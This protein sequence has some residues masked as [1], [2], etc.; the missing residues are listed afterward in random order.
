MKRWTV[1]AFG[2]VSCLAIA[3]S[4][5]KREQPPAAPVS[6]QGAA[7]TGDSPASEPNAKEPDH[8]SQV[9]KAE[10]PVAS[11]SAIAAGE[12]AVPTFAAQLRGALDEGWK[13]KAHKGSSEERLL[14]E[15]GDQRKVLQVAWEATEEQLDGHLLFRL[16]GS[17]WTPWEPSDV[18]AFALCSVSNVPALPLRQL[19]ARITS[20]TPPFRGVS[21]A[22]GEELPAV[23]ILGDDWYRYPAPLCVS[24]D[25]V[26]GP[27]DAGN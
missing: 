5:D 26:V 22:D 20:E 23:F 19:A 11:G 15:K 14:F 2:I 6:R 3:P 7:Q 16:T 18:A 4:C 25:D 12:G 13:L 21:L 27:E 8:R 9:T 10:E 24:K 1:T 17:T